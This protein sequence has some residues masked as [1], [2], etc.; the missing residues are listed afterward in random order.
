MVR[1]SLRWMPA[2]LVP[3]VIGTGV[4]VAGASPV[5][6]LE[7]KTP[8]QVLALVAASDVR[9]FS[10]TIQQTSRLGLPEIPSTG[11][12]SDSTTDSDAVASALELITG[13]HEA[14]VFVDGPER[15]RV[16]ITEDLAERDV[17]R[18]GSEVWTYDSESKEATHLTLPD[19]TA[20]HDSPTWTPGEIAARALAAVTPS[21]EVSLDPA[22]RVAG[23]STYELVLTPR[24]EDTLVGSVTIAVDSESGMPLAASVHARG[25]SAPA[26]RVAFTAIDLAA[27]AAH[28]FAFRPPAEATVTEES[29]PD[30]ALPGTPHAR[31]FR[32]AV[33]PFGVSGSDWS[34]VVELPSASAPPELLAS[35]LFASL[36]TPVDG[37]KL[38][39]SALLN[40]LVTDDGRVF[41]G[42]VPLNVLQDA[43]ANR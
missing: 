37:G 11:S 5:V 36:A 19:K 1:S 42:A 12:G 16:Q 17:I 21:T 22:S 43:A 29:V 38:L 40:V 30:A 9:S 34:T 10:G 41:A 35:P 4:V 23:R 7:E 27:P 33:P 13:S 20:A 28:L 18:S 39:G 6:T 26:F 25:E 32:S 14:R 31:D 24:T 3:L 15:A 8:E 2:V